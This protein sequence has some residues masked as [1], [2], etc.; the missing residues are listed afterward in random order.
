MSIGE[1]EGVLPPCPATRRG[2]GIQLHAS[3]KGDL[4][5]YTNGKNVIIRSIEVAPATEI[6]YEPSL[7]SVL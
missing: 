5:A 3:G 2:Y 6:A 7:P 1:I 4:L